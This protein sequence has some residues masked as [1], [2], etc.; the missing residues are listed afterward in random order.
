MAKGAHVGCVFQITLFVNFYVVNIGSLINSGGSHGINAMVYLRGHRRDYDDWHA[1]GNPTWSY[2]E[3]LKYFRKSEQNVDEDL[4]NYENGKYHSSKGLLKVGPYR[5]KN[6]T[7]SIEDCFIAAGKEAGYDLVQDFNSDTILGFG[8]AQGTVYNGRRQSTAK[9]FLIPAKDRPNLHI[10]KHAQATKIEIDDNGKATGVE[11]VYNGKE[12]LI[13]KMNKEVIVSG[14]AISSPH[15]L[16]LSG[17]GPEKQ[18]KK[19]KIPVKNNL[20]VGKNLQD[21][22]IIP[23]YFSF[24]K[25]TSH[26][27]KTD[28]ILQNVADFILHNKGD[29]TAIGI[30]DLVGYINTVNGTGYPDIEI[31]HFAF[32]KEATGLK[33][34][35]GAMEYREDM[36]KMLIEENKQNEVGMTF[37]VLINP[38]S[39]GS[40]K[41]SSADP[42]DKPNIFANYLD[43]KDDWQTILNGVKYGYDQTKSKAFKEHEGTF[44]RLPLPECDEL[45]F[46]SDEYF[47]CYINQMGTSVYHPVGTARMGPNTD[48]KAVV[49]SRLRVHGMPNIRVADASIMPKIISANT[50]APVIFRLFVINNDYY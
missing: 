42:M 10:I 12:K 29:H 8:R 14:G 50:N 24:H 15:L 11:F 36:E 45:P 5:S 47:K 20:A 30:T 18:L 25:S 46:P 13:A 7:H 31:H 28:D 38:K 1:F 35:M 49:D 4:V 34:I 9:A 17:I 37:V 16:L 27:S 44:L 41:L 26:L 23:M 3:V 39:R 19:H 32:N 43:E 6:D 48:K 33:I 2:D 21:H 40:I 22:L